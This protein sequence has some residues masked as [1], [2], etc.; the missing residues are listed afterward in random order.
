MFGRQYPIWNNI[1]ACIYKSGVSYGVKDTGVNNIVVGSSS[2]NSHDFLETIVT[3]RFGTHKGKRC[4]VFSFSIDN[5]IVK[6]MIFSVDK[7]D[8]A[9]KP[10][11]TIS[12][13]NKIKSL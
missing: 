8:R 11:K 6:K 9:V 4:V 2:N 1:T 7:K 5:V 12:K 13:L 10:L 3:R